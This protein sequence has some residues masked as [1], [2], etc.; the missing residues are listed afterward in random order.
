MPTTL[1]QSKK[2]QPTIFHHSTNHSMYSSTILTN[3][4]KDEKFLVLSISEQ[5]LFYYLHLT[6]LSWQVH[7]IVLII[8]L[9]SC[10]CKAG[11]LRNKWHASSTIMIK[12]IEEK[13]EAER[14]TVPQETV[15]QSNNYT[16]E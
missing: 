14:G 8:I 13:L 12:K 5:S 11:K 3:Q 2:Q 4:A 15:Q 6:L 1:D 16:V 10:C 7:C 9:P